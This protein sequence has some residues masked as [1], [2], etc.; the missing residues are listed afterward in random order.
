MPAT[1]S[2]PRNRDMPSSVPTAG[3]DD[4]AT[5][6]PEVAAEADGW[7]PTTVKAG[8][9]TQKRQWRCPEGHSYLAT[10]KNRTVGGTGC[11]ICAGRQVLVG[12]NDLQSQR[13]DI[14]AEA[15][16]WDPKEVTVGSGKK[17]E[18]ICPK[19]HLY[20]QII[21]E[22]TNKERNVGCPYCAGKRVLAGFNDLLTCYPNIAGW[23]YCWDPRKVTSKSE[24]KLEWKCPNGHIFKQRVAARTGG[25]GCPYCSK[26][27]SSS[28]DI[29][30]NDL[31]SQ[32]PEIAREADGWDPS[33]V[34]AKSHLMKEWKC[35]LGHQYKA[36][37]QNRTQLKS[38]CP[39]CT[40]RTVLEGFN[41]L[42][43]TFP[44]LAAEAYEWDP[45]QYTKGNIEK[46]Q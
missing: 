43:T 17:K 29:G 12:F 35:P 36:K 24:K 16:R 11:P 7:D 18:W 26:Y 23:A 30:K 3:V 13:P 10:P 2:A 41:D 38:S 37:V 31:K 39:V 33:S 28:V 40:G 21:N 15:H 9:S 42:K 20:E 8:S 19:G 14:A 32:Y 27:G 22:R 6:F 34:R 25:N 1:G 46:M 44:E 4:L 5:L 45:T